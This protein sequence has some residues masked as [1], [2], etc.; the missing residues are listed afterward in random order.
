MFLFGLC[1]SKENCDYASEDAEY[2]ANGANDVVVVEQ[3]DGSLD[4]TPFHVQI[5]KFAN[6]RTIIRSRQGRHVDIYIN[7]IRS[8]VKMTIG[9][10]GFAC[11]SRKKLK[12][13]FSNEELKL[14]KLKKGINQGLYKV[15]LN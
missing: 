2:L 14:F 13:K 6:W 7:G 11:F 5:G 1:Y 4:S 12:Y 8:P 3:T 15:I 10:S 9:D